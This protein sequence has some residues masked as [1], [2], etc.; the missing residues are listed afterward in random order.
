MHPL[1]AA[2][3]I[4]VGGGLLESFAGLLGGPS[5]AEKRATEVFGL[6]RN[7][8]GG[9]VLGSPD[10]YMSDYL[11]QSSARWNPAAEGIQRRV[12]L[13]SPTGAAQLWKLMESDIAG[14]RLNVRMQN[15]LAK[16]TNDIAL[17]R[18]MASLSG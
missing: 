17:L 18:T 16:A 11:R 10:Q 15:E 1:I 4:Q 2:T 8:L 3:G 5:D 13:D 12:G 6:L 14:F 9:D 7:R